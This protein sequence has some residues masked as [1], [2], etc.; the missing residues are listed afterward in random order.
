MAS[1][2]ENS[3]LFSLT[4]SRKKNRTNGQKSK[5]GKDTLSQYMICQKKHE[6][7]QKS[8][9]NSSINHER[10]CKQYDEEKKKPYAMWAVRQNSVKPF[11]HTLIV[12]PQKCRQ[13]VCVIALSLSYN[14]INQRKSNKS[15]VR[16]NRFSHGCFHLHRLK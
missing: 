7:Q 10:R 12:S 2:R 15:F 11:L 4:D 8:N 3:C 13:M 6:Q 1:G 14:G 5:A 16:D 9:L